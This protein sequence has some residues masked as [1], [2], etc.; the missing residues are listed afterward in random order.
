MLEIGLSTKTQLAIEHGG[1]RVCEGAACS[2]DNYTIDDST[3]KSGSNDNVALVNYTT[4]SISRLKGG[5]ELI[6]CHC[7]MLSRSKKRKSTVLAICTSL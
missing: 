3:I 1:Y 2:G 4:P 5:F 6:R 7:Q